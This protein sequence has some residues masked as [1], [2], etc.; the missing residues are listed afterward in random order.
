MPLYRAAD[1]RNGVVSEPTTA[2]Q[3]LLKRARKI[4][5]SV[6]KHYGCEREHTRQLFIHVKPKD[7][8]WHPSSRP[9]GARRAIGP[10]RAIGRCVLPT[11]LPHQL[12][13]GAE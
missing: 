6:L 11:S 12:L 3:R 9:I 8:A 4:A 5:F 13:A 1:L 7:L 2:H 10:R